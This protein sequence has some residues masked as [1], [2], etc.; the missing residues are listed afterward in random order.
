MLELLLQVRNLAGEG[1]IKPDPCAHHPGLCTLMAAVE[2]AREEVIHPLQ[3]WPAQRMVFNKK[4]CP[5]HPNR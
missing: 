1:K 3:P 2:A 5:R 4:S